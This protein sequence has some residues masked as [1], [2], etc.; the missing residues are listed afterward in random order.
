MS[1]E[2]CF[3]MRSLSTILAATLLTACASTPPSAPIV[4]LKIDLP[5]SVDWTQITN[6]SDGRQSIREWVPAGSSGA[7]T[8][9]II[10][11]QKLAVPES[12]T[13]QKMLSTMFETAR[14]LCTDVLYNGPERL[15]VE[16]HETWVGRTMCAQQRGN[17][18]GT[19]TDQRV[20]ISEGFAFVVTSELRVP[21]SPKAGVIAMS[22]ADSSDVQKFV[23][24]QTMSARF[25]RSSVRT[26][27]AAVPEC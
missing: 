6:Q 4:S 27:T 24:K 7:Q 3:A 12:A 15:D 26:C 19:F 5:F 13:A 16:G 17:P 22:N 18:Y 23:E 14:G 8:D 25:V 20:T 11:E 9:W 10:V 21:S 1:A 2:E